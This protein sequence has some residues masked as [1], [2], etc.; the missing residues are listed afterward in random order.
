MFYISLYISYLLHTVCYFMV[1]I[2]LLREICL[3]SSLEVVRTRPDEIAPEYSK[4]DRTNVLRVL[5]SMC[6]KYDG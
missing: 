3:E 4:R 2:G 6:S 1:V 5:S